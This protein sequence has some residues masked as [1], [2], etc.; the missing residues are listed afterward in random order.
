M[1][2]L[3]KPTLVNGS[4]RLFGLQDMAELLGMEL[5]IYF[6]KIF[7]IQGRKRMNYGCCG[8]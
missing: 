2:E 6:Q 3:E 7:N 8:R 4:V 1:I 5:I